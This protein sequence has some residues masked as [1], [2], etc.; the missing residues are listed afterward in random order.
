MDIPLPRRQHLWGVRAIHARILSRQIK[1]IIK[2][3]LQSRGAPPT[4]KVAVRQQKS[5]KGRYQNYHE[6]RLNPNLNP[7]P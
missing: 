4:M 2:V 1:V 6:M 3:D 7:K 5:L